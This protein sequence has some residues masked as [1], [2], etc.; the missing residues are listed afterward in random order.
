MSGISSLS[1]A[2]TAIG[3]FL[4]EVSG[5]VSKPTEYLNDLLA[6][7]ANDARCQLFAFRDDC[8]VSYDDVFSGYIIYQASF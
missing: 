3:L 1:N 4:S 6:P 2:E 7:E 8:E 5:V